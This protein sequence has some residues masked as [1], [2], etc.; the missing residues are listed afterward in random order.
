[1]KL[2]QNVRD[3]LRDRIGPLADVL[4]ELLAS[5]P[6]EF[7]WIDIKKRI[8]RH[9]NRADL[10]DLLAEH[11]SS[12]RPATNDLACAS[13]LIREKIIG[14]SEVLQQTLERMP[15]NAILKLVYAP[16]RRPDLWQ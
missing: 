6:D 7:R 15:R 8:D 13:I 4:P 9:L 1:M 16:D 3:Y 10:R 2:R 12:V 11:D 5:L 14:D